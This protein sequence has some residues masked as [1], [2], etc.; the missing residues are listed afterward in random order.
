MELIKASNAKDLGIFGKKVPESLATMFPQKAT[1][2]SGHKNNSVK[3]GLAPPNDDP[4]T[5]RPTTSTYPD[6]DAEILNSH[7]CSLMSSAV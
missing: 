1:R 3:A 5:N 7:L 2:P 4:N 6:S